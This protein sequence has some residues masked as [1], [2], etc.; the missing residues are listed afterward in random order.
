MEQKEGQ[1]EAVVQ[2]IPMYISLYVVVLLKTR[3]ST[4]CASLAQLCF[5][6]WQSD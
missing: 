2:L 6:S 4:E 1:T 5:I 3:G